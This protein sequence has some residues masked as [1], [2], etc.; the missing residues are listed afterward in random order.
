MFQLHLTRVNFHVLPVVTAQYLGCNTPIFLES[1]NGRELGNKGKQET[2][3]P[4]SVETTN[5]KLTKNKIKK[6]C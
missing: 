4:L 6:Y 2:Y 3:L 1:D 5:N